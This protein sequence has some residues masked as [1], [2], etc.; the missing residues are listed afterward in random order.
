MPIHLCATP[1]IAPILAHFSECTPYLLIPSWHKAETQLFSEASSASKEAALEV[2]VDTVVML[3][4]GLLPKY[5][6]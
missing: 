3:P 6:D 4:P 5:F 1:L 2:G